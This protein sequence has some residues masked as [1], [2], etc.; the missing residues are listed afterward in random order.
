MIISVQMKQAAWSTPTQL[1]W[2]N[3]PGM[4]SERQQVLHLGVALDWVGFVLH[5]SVETVR[6]VCRMGRCCHVSWLV[7]VEKDKAWEQSVGL[8]R[9]R[10]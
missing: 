9:C 1:A 7:S 3:R 6:A 2:V 10:L 4:L 8:A 5:H